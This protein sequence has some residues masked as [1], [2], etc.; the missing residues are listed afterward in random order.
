MRPSRRVGG[1]AAAHSPLGAMNRAG[2]P[3]GELGERG[4][5]TL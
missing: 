3:F 5:F 1:A 4:F 2:S